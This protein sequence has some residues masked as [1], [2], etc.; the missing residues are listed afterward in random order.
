MLKK[1]FTKHEANIIEYLMT[2]KEPVYLTDI[3]LNCHLRQPTVS[4][5]MRH[6][7]TFNF[8]EQSETPEP[9]NGENGKGRPRNTYRLD[10]KKLI[11]Y[12]TNTHTS[13]LADAQ[14][15][16]VFITTL[17]KNLNQKPEDQDGN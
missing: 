13:I 17:I 1:Y 14:D 5:A 9:S 7:Q 10:P 11:N 3:E 15:L 12:L 6:L 2:K 8:I 16:H 4:V